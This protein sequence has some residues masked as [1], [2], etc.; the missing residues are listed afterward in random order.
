MKPSLN[1]LDVALGVLLGGL[2][3]D[4]IHHL[5]GTYVLSQ[6]HFPPPTPVSSTPATPQAPTQPAVQESSPAT[7]EPTKQR[8]AYV[9]NE[10][11]GKRV[12]LHGPQ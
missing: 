4:G 11:T 6:I 5:E 10:K 3:L 1:I 7:T 2:A 8:P 12:D 9:I